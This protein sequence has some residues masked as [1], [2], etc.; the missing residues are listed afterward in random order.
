MIFPS[1]MVYPISLGKPYIFFVQTI[2]I[3]R[4]KQEPVRSVL[5]S[6]RLCLHRMT[7]WTNGFIP[8]RLFFKSYFEMKRDIN[9]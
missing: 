4:S 5:S 6:V 7:V 3:L 8:T 9:F 2:T 1:H